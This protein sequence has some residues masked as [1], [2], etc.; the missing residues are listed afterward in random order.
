VK[1]T[2]T[3]EVLLLSWIGLEDQLDTYWRQK[4]HVKWLDKRDRNPDFF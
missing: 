2:V 1:E 4:A 3:R